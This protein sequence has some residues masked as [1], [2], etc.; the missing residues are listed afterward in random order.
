MKEE[1]YT[2]DEIIALVDDLEVLKE[3]L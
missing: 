3:Y 2:A 1:Y